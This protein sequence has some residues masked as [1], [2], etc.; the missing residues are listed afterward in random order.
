M[1]SYLKPFVDTMNRL[2]S[3][4]ISW[5]SQAGVPQTCRVYP[6]PCSVDTVARC[7]VMNMTQF[8]GSHSCAWCEQEGEVVQKGRG[9]A[10][11][12]EIQ[13]P[14]PKERTQENFA[15]H[16]E[17]ANKQKEV[18]YGIRGASVLFF[19]AFF[20]FPGS[21]VV[22]YMHA[23]CNGF[24]RST[25]FLWFSHKRQN[26]FSLGSA[27]EE[28]NARLSK[29]TPVWETNRLPR[30]L[31][32]MKYW[33]AS[34]WR[35][36]LLF[37]SPV[38]LNGILP[39]KY[40]KN[41]TKFVG[42]MHFCLQSSIP[43]DKLRKVKKAM[44]NFLK[45]Y[46]ELYGKENMTYNA[47]I[48]VHMVDHVGQWGPL[49]GYSAF[50]FEAMN[51][52]LV[53]LVNGTR[54][55]HTQIVEKF[56]ILAFLQRA[57][58]MNTEWQSEDLRSFVRSLLKGYCLRKNCVQKGVVA[59][60][61]KGKNEGGFITYKKATVGA[62]TYCINTMDKSRRK[63]SYVLTDAGF[64][65]QVINIST[66]VNLGSQVLFKLRKLRIMDTFLSCVAG[67]ESVRFA[68]VSETNEHVLVD[69]GQIK[70]CML[71]CHSGTMVLCALNEEYILESN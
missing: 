25:A 22:D 48:L 59:L 7:M 67:C 53:G 29:M 16:V 55:A 13:E 70:K 47:H 64:F 52:R 61:G 24:V 63:N 68:T 17:K 23:V 57:V 35:D 66:D 10:R 28:I 5:N 36:W 32:D 40:Y 69:S 43:M 38:V 15:R 46:Q 51:G 18:A 1:N 11:I 39:R 9:H 71:L 45:E 37:F 50:P 12:F 41:W 8:N 21:F 4:G 31:K 56:G 6:G 30:S 33:K 65:G 60:Y 2:S 44:L 3:E 54:Y 14:A 49:W 20:Q 26:D 19:V 58:P 27:L 42:I 34:E 62:F